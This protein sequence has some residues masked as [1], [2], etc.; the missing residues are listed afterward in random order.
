VP[1]LHSWCVF[2][3]LSLLIGDSWRFL[4]DSDTGWHIRTGEW[5]L[6]SGTV[7]R[8]DLFSYTMQGRR[9]FAWEW[10]SDVLIAGAYHAAGLAGVV[11]AAIL[12]LLVTFAAL[13]RLLVWRG[14][15]PLLALVLTS[16]GASV[17]LIHWLARPHLLS[18]LLMLVWVAV[19]EN[20]RHR[21]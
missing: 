1:S 13:D 16:F 4:V 19:V 10:L 2:A 7:P 14:A 15:D 8:E 12:V 11:S 5:I 20:F 6:Q 3:V 17:T 21:R 18:M 9:W